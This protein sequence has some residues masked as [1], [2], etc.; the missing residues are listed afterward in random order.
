[1]IKIIGCIVLAAALSCIQ[2]VSQGTKKTGATKDKNMFASNEC[3]AKGG[4]GIVNT[5]LYIDLKSPKNELL[6]DAGNRWTGQDARTQEVVFFFENRI[7][8]AQAPLNEFDLSKAI[9]ISFE[10]DKVRFFDFGKM[11]GG[12]YTRPKQN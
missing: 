7:W 2:G 11:S 4:I 1:M 5:N 9:V 8:S 3:F 12:Y 6:M 10:V